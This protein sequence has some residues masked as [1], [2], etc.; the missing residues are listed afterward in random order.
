MKDEIPHTIFSK[1]T[2]EHPNEKVIIHSGS[3]TVL[4]GKIQYYFI[5]DIW[6]SWFPNLK[7]CFKGINEKMGANVLLISSEVK[8]Q[9]KEN[10]LENGVITEQSSNGEVSGFFKNEVVYGD[11]S[12][13]VDSV[14]FSITN[15]RSFMGDALMVSAEKWVRGRLKFEVDDIEIIIDKVDDYDK[16][17]KSLKEIGGFLVLYNGIL[18]NKQKS[19]NFKAAS[20]KLSIFL[21]FLWFLNGRRC[22]ILFRTGMYEGNEVWCDYGSYNADPIKSVYSWPE[23]YSIEGLNELWIN[24]NKVWKEDNDFL[25]TAIHWYLEA[26]NNSGLVEGSI[27]MIQ[28]ALELIYNWYIVEQKK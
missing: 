21:N 13:N 2:M 20:E 6:Y 25:N 16:K 18:S 24:F 22:A 14:I 1:K 11:K 3:F 28:T 10:I 15:L 19:I 4:D 5:G 26:N 23:N 17:S 7:L 8:I 12:I 9:F 27:I